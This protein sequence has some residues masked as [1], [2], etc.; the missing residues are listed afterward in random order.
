[1]IT[2]GAAALL[3]GRQVRLAPVG[4]GDL[5]YVLGLLDRDEIGFRWL[6]GGPH[7]TP[8]SLQAA[9]ASAA[10][11]SFLAIPRWTD[12]PAGLVG[13]YDA[14][15]DAGHARIALVPEFH[16]QAVELTLQAGLLLVEF[17]VATWRFR[18]LYAE[19]PGISDALPLS[20]LEGLVTEEA[21]LR[22]HLYYRGTF[23]DLPIYAIY[24]DRWEELAEPILDAI[25]DLGQ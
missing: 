4:A 24:R 5:T 23:I 13:L 19:L 10:L 20:Q 25:Q 3:E 18:K 9:L 17:A 12:H 6:H 14:D 7:H 11:A 1:M 16:P 15:F 21:R 22:D 8:A 2:A